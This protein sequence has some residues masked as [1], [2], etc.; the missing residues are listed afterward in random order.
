M[1]NIEQTLK[2]N[3]GASEIKENSGPPY[4]PGDEFF[5]RSGI[6]INEI[7]KSLAIIPVYKK[8]YQY[9]L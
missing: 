8:L 5:V 9:Q 4:Q 6:L 7:E 2:T 3:L 1:P